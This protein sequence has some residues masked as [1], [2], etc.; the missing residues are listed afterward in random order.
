MIDLAGRTNAWWE[1]FGF[2]EYLRAI[3]KGI[4]TS[5]WP[6][7]TQR[8]LVR[9]KSNLTKPRSVIFFTTHKCAST[10]VSGRPFRAIFSGSQ[11]KLIDYANAIWTSGKRLDLQ[12]RHEEFLSNAYSELYS[13]HGAIYAPQRRHLDFPGRELFRHIFFLRDP[14]DILI[15]SYYSVAF[16]HPVPYRSE[17]RKRMAQSRATAREQEIDDYVMGQAETWLKPLFEQ[18]I[19]L[20]ESA[21]DSLYLKYD[22]FVENTAEFVRELCNFLH[23]NPD[24]KAVKLLIDQ[25]TP[26][27]KTE[28]MR[29]K[30]SGR[31]GQY[32]EKL[33]PDTVNALN[34]MLANVLD[35]WEF[36]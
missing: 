20:R 26:V 13:M 19:L 25:A 17:S 18:Y 7:K 33:R 6:T 34:D 27:Q 36:R 16:T 4:R 10:F 5:L 35:Y 14:R 24:S 21:E 11:Y 12:G 29:H 23:L 15:S 2:L 1:Q 28:V 32:I 31:S 22:F 8:Q 30:R 3:V 9:A